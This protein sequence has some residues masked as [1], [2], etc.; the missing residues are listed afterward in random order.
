MELTLKER[1]RLYVLRQ[2]GEGRFR[3][4]RRRGVWG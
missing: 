4:Q 3:E 1:D 2:A